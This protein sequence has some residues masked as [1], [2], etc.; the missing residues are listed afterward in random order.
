MRLWTFEVRGGRL[1]TFQIPG[2]PRIPHTGY[3]LFHWHMNAP[4]AVSFA[5]DL[6]QRGYQVS[7]FPMED[8]NEEQLEERAK[9][10]EQTD[11][12][13]PCIKC[14]ECFWFDPRQD[15]PCLYTGDWKDTREAI[16]VWWLKGREDL[17]ACPVLEK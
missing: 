6:E 12:V 8:E 9:L 17:D 14:P 11:R 13:W 7:Y 10:T 5:K 3:S 1:N 15:D 2:N 4:T 16:M